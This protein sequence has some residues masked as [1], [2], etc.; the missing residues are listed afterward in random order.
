MATS[1][2]QAEG[3]TVEFSNVMQEL[4]K[5]D[6]DVTAGVI[7]EELHDTHT[8]PGHAGDYQINLTT[9][10]T[11]ILEAMDDAREHESLL[12]TLTHGELIA[13]HSAYGSQADGD[14]HRMKNQMRLPHPDEVF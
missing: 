3:R 1:Q 5:P 10:L 7:K 9:A 12:V 14:E 6:G 2:T 8:R 13:I 11:K 4:P